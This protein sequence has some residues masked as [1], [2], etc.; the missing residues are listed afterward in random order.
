MHYRN[1]TFSTEWQRMT[2]C[3]HHQASGFLHPRFLHEWHRRLDL[4]Y[5]SI[6]PG[7]LEDPWKFTSSLSP[8]QPSR[9]ISKVDS[10]IRE[11]WSAS[12][13]HKYSDHI[14]Y[15]ESTRS[16]SRQVK[17]KSILCCIQ[18][19]RYFCQHYWQ[20]RRFH[21]FFKSFLTK[22]SHSSLCHFL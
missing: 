1:Y 19:K 10:R 6:S 20:K 14:H 8:W 11:L 15:F 5:S 2:S 17:R 21:S 3:S 16:K 4:R 12:I 18:S 9:G 7:D 13:D 22:H